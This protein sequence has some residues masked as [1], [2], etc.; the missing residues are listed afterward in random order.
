MKYRIL[1]FVCFVFVLF[2]AS[3]YLRGSS[4]GHPKEVSSQVQLAAACGSVWSLLVKIF[5]FISFLSLSFYSFPLPFVSYN[6]LFFPL[7]TFLCFSLRSF[8]FW[9]FATQKKQNHFFFSLFHN[10]NRRETMVSLSIR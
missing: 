8:Q 4:F 10:K 2:A 3:L 9:Q 5:S 6:F 7:V 1:R